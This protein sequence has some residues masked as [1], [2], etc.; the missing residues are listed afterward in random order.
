VAAL[1]DERRRLEQDLAKLRQELA[2]GTGAASGPEAKEVAGIRYAGRSVTGI[3]AKDL[4]G[5]A[6]A[7][8][9]RI[10]PGVAAVVS[11]VD[12]KAAL[13]VAVSED[14][15]GSVDAVELVRAGVAELGGKGG[16]GRPNFAQGG[17]PDGD[18]AEAALA[19]IERVLSAH[20]AAA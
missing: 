8:Q 2:A 16:G 20:A 18:R 13:V 4:R 14:L 12:G 9:K 10:R 15:E 5:I 7:L 1:L 3:P 11:T 6:D 19:A 17:G